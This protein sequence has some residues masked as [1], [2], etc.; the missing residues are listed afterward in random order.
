MS[1]IIIIQTLENRFQFSSENKEVHSEKN[2]TL[3][4]RIFSLIFT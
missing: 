2:K 3:L 4:Q 1:S